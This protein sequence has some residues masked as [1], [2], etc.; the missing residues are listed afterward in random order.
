MIKIRIIETAELALLVRA[1]R[2]YFV[3]MK[4][5]SLF[6]LY[7]YI[8]RCPPDDM[9][10]FE[11]TAC[12]RLEL[13]YSKLELFPLNDIKSWLVGCFGLNGPLRQ[14]FSLYRAVSQREG[15]RKEKR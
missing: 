13:T 2:P 8:L 6:V 5:T 4:K 14:Y 10:L 9:V 3:E 1:D 15:E 11:D 7:H 12:P